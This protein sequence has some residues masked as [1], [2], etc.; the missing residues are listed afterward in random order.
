MLPSWGSIVLDSD[1]AE[2]LGVSG[3][4]R[5]ED[6]RGLIDTEAKRDLH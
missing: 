3:S 4:G 5:P 6:R 2:N 1:A